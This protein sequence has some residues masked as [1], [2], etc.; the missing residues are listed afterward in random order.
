MHYDH[1]LQ[2]ILPCGYRVLTFLVQIYVDFD[3]VILHNIAVYWDQ[4][5]LLTINYRFNQNSNGLLTI[6]EKNL[7]EPTRN[8]EALLSSIFLIIMIIFFFF[9]GF[10]YVAPSIFENWK[11]GQSFSELH[12]SKSLK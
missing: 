4:R 10:T 5:V 9:Q 11:G 2:I 3:H 6:S 1:Q 7:S 8:L 12:I